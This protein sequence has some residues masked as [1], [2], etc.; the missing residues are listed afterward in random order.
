MAP[1]DAVQA[2]IDM[3]TDTNKYV[4]DRAPWKEVKT[5]LAA[6]A[7]TLYVGLETLRVAGILLS[8][9]MPEKMHTLL[10]QLGWDKKPSFADAEKFGALVAGTK[11]S[12]GDPLFPR[13]EWKAEEQVKA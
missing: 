1:Q 8:P 9:V 7:E 4:G 12:K 2:V 10:R 13:V 11:I 6:A 3:L 5:D